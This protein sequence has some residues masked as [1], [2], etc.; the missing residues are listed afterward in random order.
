MTNK[1]LIQQYVTTGRQLPEHQLKQLNTNQMKSYL[2]QRIL[3]QEYSVPFQQYE[4]LLAP[5]EIKPYIIKS[6]S[7][8]QEFIEFL[9]GKTEKW[10]STNGKTVYRYE[11]I[12]EFPTLV[13]M[14]LESYNEETENPNIWAIK[15]YIAGMVSTPDNQDIFKIKTDTQEVYNI[16]LSTPDYGKDKT[17]LDYVYT[18]LGT[19]E[20]LTPFKTF[21]KD[22]F[23]A[24]VK[25]LKNMSGETRLKRIG[26]I[27]GSS[28]IPNQIIELFDSYDSMGEDFLWYM[29]DNTF[30]DLLDTKHPLHRIS[31]MP[32]KKIKSMVR[33]VIHRFS[34][35][36]PEEYAQGFTNPKEVMQIYNMYF[37]G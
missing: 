36:R 2:R 30:H 17:D 5:N 22:K 12:I 10:Y 15:D 31:L 24:Y 14:I 28:P 37:D 9:N 4:Y 29:S 8:D 32:E 11:P 13:K 3:A 19:T 34:L 23:E 16:L 20:T 25:K 1:D 26:H 27:F 33:N 6:I 35:G 7:T 21:A 18:I